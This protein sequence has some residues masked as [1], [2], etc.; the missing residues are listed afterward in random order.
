[1]KKIVVTVLAMMVCF[2][3]CSKDEET[4]Q[5][6]GKVT[7]EN[8]FRGKRV[9]EK[10]SYGYFD[11]YTYDQDGRLVSV[12]SSNEEQVL[13]YENNKLIVIEKEGDEIEY[14]ST[15]I[16][17]ENGFAESGTGVYYE[18]GEDGVM[19]KYTS[20][21]EFK[22]TSDGYLSEAKYVED[23]GTEEEEEFVEKYV[24]KDG[25]IV[26]YSSVEDGKT[27]KE[28][29]YTTGT[30]ENKG[31]ALNSNDFDDT[32]YY[33]GVLGKTS[34]NL[35]TKEEST[36]YHSGTPNKA[37]YYCDYELDKDGYVL[38]EKLK[39]EVSEDWYV[40]DSYKYN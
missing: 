12:K 1:M 5:E 28:T 9:A 21:Y 16:I 20:T 33:A 3:G 15:F 34:K 36:D 8:V 14:E 7:P 23:E 27:Y 17:N 22:Y 10:G 30:V 11:K 19:K 32:L 18:E 39:P 4:E 24:Y 6:T 26:S 25:N 40:G 38:K 37:V 2:V 35:I 29:T 31:G 13:K